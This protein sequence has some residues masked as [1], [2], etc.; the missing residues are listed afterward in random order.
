MRAIYE[1]PYRDP[2]SANYQ[3]RKYVKGGEVQDGN[4]VTF[5]CAEHMAAAKLEQAKRRSYDEAVSN[6]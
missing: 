6:P 4:D 5:L 3:I 2:A 1:N